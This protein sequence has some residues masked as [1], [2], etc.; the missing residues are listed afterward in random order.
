MWVAEVTVRGEALYPAH[1]HT[2]AVLAEMRFSQQGAPGVRLV[3][4]LEDG[5]S[6]HLHQQHEVRGM[7]GV[8]AV[9]GR[10]KVSHLRWCAESRRGDTQETRLNIVPIVPLARSVPA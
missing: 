9:S 6:P 3:F 4:C 5:S 2:P 8:L 1:R 7:G 10:D